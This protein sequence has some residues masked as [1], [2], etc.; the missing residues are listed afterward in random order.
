MIVLFALLL[1]AAG[2]GG[3]ASG[4]T[5]VVAEPPR[6]DF[7]AVPVGRS[8]AGRFVLKNRGEAPIVLGRIEADAPLRGVVEV[9]SSVRTLRPGSET[10]VRVLF[11]PTREGR[12]MGD[13]RVEGEGAE[14]PLLIV[15]ITGVGIPGGL[16]FDPAEVDFGRIRVGSTALEQVTIA[17]Q[18]EVSVEL[19]ALALDVGSSTAFSTR[20]SS[21][22]TLEP[23]DRVVAEIEFSPAEPGLVVGQVRAATVGRWP[24]AGAALLIGEGSISD[25][26]AEP[27]AVGIEGAA[28]GEVHARPVRIRNLSSAPLEL[29]EVR[30]VS[31]EATT[32]LFVRPPPPG[33]LGPGAHVDVEVVF[34]PTRAGVARAHLLV[35]ASTGDEV[36]VPIEAEAQGER[37]P[38]PLLGGGRLDFGRVTVGHRTSRFLW[39]DVAGRARLPAETPAEVTPAGAPFQLVEPPGALA[40][41]ARRRLELVFL[42][43][44]PGAFGG[45]LWV[46]TAS[47]AVEGA[48]AS[49]PVGELEIWPQDLDFGRVPRGVRSVRRFLL[50]SLG[51]A[52]VEGLRVEASAPFSVLEPP[53][54][55]L[56]P[57][58]SSVVRIAFF[59]EERFGGEVRSEV[60]VRWADQPASRV[61][62]R[63]D[64]RPLP[65]P[66]PEVEIVLRWAGDGAL[67][68]H[69]AERDAEVFEVPGS[70]SFCNPSPRWGDPD[71]E[72]DDPWLEADYG[73]GPAEERIVLER[74]TASAYRIEVVHEGGL[75]VDADLEVKAAGRPVAR[76]TRRLGPE[77]RWTVG[78]V[79]RTDGQLELEPFAL[80]LVV[81]TRRLCD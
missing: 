15:P 70:A 24:V 1:W 57:G 76:E 5:G 71:D 50:R 41:G 4:L 81:E 6:M 28:V 80:P 30:L 29:L 42:P 27:A 74:A 3:G 67:D 12:W 66:D 62:V 79:R 51:T 2:C 8:A 39:L 33:R 9:V 37:A 10:E 60:A 34:A 65:V 43:P 73:V 78:R 13:L 40:P 77:R 59:E 38:T 20:L 58:A 56:P 17:N 46:G 19:S 54:S 25:L 63:A 23:G 7:G 26:L 31:G 49:G 32:D 21:V 75:P 11:Q 72:S 16:R 22:A 64:I 45:T 35:R 18:G 69:L 53:P 44:A 61:R 52:E 36:E 14:G 47:R 55:R 48:G 68:L